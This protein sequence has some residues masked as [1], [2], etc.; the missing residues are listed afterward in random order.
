MFYGCSSLVSLPDISK[1]NTK[2]VT[3]IKHIFDRFSKL[4]VKPY[5]KIN[6]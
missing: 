4:L 1:W 3:N 6:K 2:N 5:L